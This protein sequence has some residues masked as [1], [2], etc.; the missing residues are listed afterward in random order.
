MEKQAGN[1][2]Y[3]DISNE[4]MA[5]Y[6]E[7]AF[8]CEKFKQIIASAPNLVKAAQYYERASKMVMVY[9]VATGDLSATAQDKILDDFALYKNECDVPFDNKTKLGGDEQYFANHILPEVIMYHQNKLNCAATAEDI[10]SSIYI[11]SEN[12]NF[13]THSFNGA[14]VGAIKKEGFDISKEKFHD[15]FN[16]LRSIG[17]FQSYKTGVLCTTELSKDTFSYARR[18]PERLYQT[19][20]VSSQRK[21]DESMRDYLRAGLQETLNKKSD[22]DENTKAKAWE[23]G[24]KIIDFYATGEGTKSAIAF[25][26]QDRN[27]VAE[28]PKSVMEHIEK[29]SRAQRLDVV[30][31]RKI[32]ESFVRGFYASYADGYVIKDGKLAPDRFAVA[33]FDNPEE[34]YAKEQRIA[35]KIDVLTAKKYEQAC[36]EK[37]YAEDFRRGVKPKESIEEFKE[38]HLEFNAMIKNENGCLVASPAFKL[39]QEKNDVNNPCRSY[40]KWAKVSVDRADNAKDKSREGGSQSVER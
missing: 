9:A 35:E 11:Q 39:W 33:I 25:I 13:E 4:E 28:M 27:V 12:T 18:C 8:N 1:Y 14:L 20:G 26:K 37:F 40:R 32:C 5:A 3:N 29:D 34:Y 10:I 24:C 2:Q 21:D 19:L 23:A 7:R 16:V 17:L 15:E 38:H 31:T 36:Y 22:L 30:L 6:F